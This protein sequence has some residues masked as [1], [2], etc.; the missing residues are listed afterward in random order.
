MLSLGKV[1]PKQ[2]YIVKLDC[3]W[4][5]VDYDGYGLRIYIYIYIHTHTHTCK[6]IQ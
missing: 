3:S 2:S 6:R 4:L 1:E 5:L